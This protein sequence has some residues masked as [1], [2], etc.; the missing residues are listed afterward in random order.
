[1]TYGYMDALVEFSEKYGHHVASQVSIPPEDVLDLRRRLI[2]EEARELI[3]ALANK[4]IRQVAD[5]CADL[6]YVTFGTALAFGIPMDRIFAEVHRSNMTK[7]YEKK[8]GKS[9]K[10]PDFRPPD[11]EQILFKS[12]RKEVVG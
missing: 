7:S 12:D 11:F 1:M 6:L 5:G 10:G 3:D 8:G 9:V 4:D 2:L